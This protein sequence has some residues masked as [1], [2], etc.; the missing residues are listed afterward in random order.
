MNA[1]PCALCGKPASIGTTD[2]KVICQQCAAATLPGHP[3]TNKKGH[4]NAH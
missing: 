2:G 4:V 3:V 1:I